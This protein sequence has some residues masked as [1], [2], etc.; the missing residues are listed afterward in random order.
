MS[1]ADDGPVGSPEKDPGEWT[2]GD[3]PVTGPQVSY[4]ATLA[5]QAGR[6]VP[7]GLTKAQASELIDELQRETGRGA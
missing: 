7:E 6:D 4:L 3:E 1:Q 5:R 2:T